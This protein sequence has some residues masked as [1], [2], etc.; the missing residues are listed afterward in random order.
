MPLQL[1]YMKLGD[2]KSSNPGLDL[3]N[4]VNLELRRLSRS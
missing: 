2:S 4:R 1:L 3:P